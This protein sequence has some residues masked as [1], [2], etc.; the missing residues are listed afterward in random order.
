MYWCN[1][2]LRGTVWI[3][4]TNLTTPRFIE[5]PVPSH[6]SEQSCNC[7]F[8]VSILPS[9]TTLIFDFVNAPTVWYFLLF[10]MP[11]EKT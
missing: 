9:S 2:C 10:S 6:E 8:G 5:V 4:K 7:V 3:Y 11:R 1:I